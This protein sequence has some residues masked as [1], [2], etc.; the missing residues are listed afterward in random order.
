M[1]IYSFEEALKKTKYSQ[2]E[3]IKFQND[4]EEDSLIDT[5]REEEEMNE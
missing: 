2:F 1:R 5:S 3:F 4:E